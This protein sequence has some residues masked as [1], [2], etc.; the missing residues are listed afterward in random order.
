MVHLKQARSQAESEAV[1]FRAGYSSLVLPVIGLI[2]L[3]AMPGVGDVSADTPR[4]ATV[5]NE[6]AQALQSGDLPAAESRFLEVLRLVPKS[7][8]AWSNLGVVHMRQ[9][10]WEKALYDLNQAGKLALRT[11]PESGSTLGW[12]TSERQI[13]RRRAVRSP[14]WCATSQILFRPV[15]C[16]RY[17]TSLRRATAT[18]W[19]YLSLF[20]T[21]SRATSTTFMCSQ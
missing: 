20:G 16:W 17:A 4:P 2:L 8:A 12:S 18:P 9:R 3:V 14:L 1:P 21:R 10:K 5:F 15:S 19:A 6:G 7:A 13:T 11:S